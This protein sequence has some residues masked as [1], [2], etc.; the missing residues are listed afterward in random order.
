M[1]L[2]VT[3]L[4]LPGGFCER[5]EYW[6]A[7]E[8]T[9]SLPGNCIY[10]VS[11]RGVVLGSS[12]MFL[13]IRSFLLFLCAVRTSGIYMI[14]IRFVQLPQEWQ[15][16]EM[17]VKL[18][19]FCCFFGSVFK[20][21]WKKLA[22]FLPVKKKKKKE[23]ETGWLEAWNSGGQILKYLPPGAHSAYQPILSEDVNSRPTA[24]SVNMDGLCVED[25]CC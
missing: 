19:L 14:L 4:F 3:L 1:L 16:R 10:L 2:N 17:C 8:G 24:A 21:K 25:V 9:R 15:R 18:Q 13:L 20:L 6:C 11:I 12:E 5:M 22:R 7:R 23:L